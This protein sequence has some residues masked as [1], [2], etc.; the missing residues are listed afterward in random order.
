M[1]PDMSI[2]FEWLTGR[3]MEM[4][5]LSSHWGPSHLLTIVI[6]CVA[7]I[8]GYTWFQSDLRDFPLFA[9]VKGILESVEN[10][11][12]RNSAPRDR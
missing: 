3:R 4:H 9:Q 12:I 6:A 10:P 2:L 7:N 8:M 1:T 11:F 5:S